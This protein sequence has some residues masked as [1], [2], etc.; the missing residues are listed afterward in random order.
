MVAGASAVEV[1]TAHFVDPQASEKLV[2]SVEKWCQD[3]NLLEISK[4]T[5]SIKA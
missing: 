3:E 5:G 2:I 4:L 1:G